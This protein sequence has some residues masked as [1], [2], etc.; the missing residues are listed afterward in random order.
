MAKEL[1]QE[2]IYFDVWE[3]LNTASVPFH[4]FTF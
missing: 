1:V 4:E 3:L 2:F